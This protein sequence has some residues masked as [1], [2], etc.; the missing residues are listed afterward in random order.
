MPLGPGEVVLI[1]PTG[2]AKVLMH[3]VLVVGDPE[4]S[5]GVD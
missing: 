4:R 3:S 2:S 1:E 5:R